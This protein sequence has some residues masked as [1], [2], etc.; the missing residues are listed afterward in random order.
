M[1]K[2]GTGFRFAQ[3]R[4]PSRRPARQRARARQRL[5]RGV[6][7][8]G[9]R[10]ERRGVSP[11]SPKVTQR[12]EGASGQRSPAAAES[13]ACEGESTGDRVSEGEL[14]GDRVSEGELSGDRVSEGELSGDR[15]ELRGAMPNRRPAEG[16]G[17]ERI[18]GECGAK[19]SDLERR[20]ATWSE[21]E[22]NKGRGAKA[23]RRRGEGEGTLACH[24]AAMSSGATASSWAAR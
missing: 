13:K 10:C 21:G 20:G 17:G 1:Y 8:P 12:T 2:F 24:G 9:E 14:G 16:S 11:P 18:R 5:R 6:C 19:G 4:R 15:G 22:R 23:R 7:V 3:Q